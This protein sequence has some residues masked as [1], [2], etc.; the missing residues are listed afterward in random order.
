[1]SEEKAN[2]LIKREQAFLVFHDQCESS[3]FSFTLLRIAAV[4]INGLALILS[5]F[6]LGFGEV[7]RTHLSG[8]H[9]GVKRAA[10]TQPFVLFIENSP[11]DGDDL[12]LHETRAA[13]RQAIKQ[14]RH[15]FD[16]VELVLLVR[17]KLEAKGQVSGPK[18]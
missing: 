11:D 14:A 16:G 15:T 9:A 10:W 12:L 2:R 7:S 18:V 6:R 5:F 3:L 17:V 8:R 4:C 1:M 13:Q